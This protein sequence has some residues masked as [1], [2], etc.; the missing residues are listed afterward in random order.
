VPENSQTFQISCMN[1]VDGW[2]QLYSTGNFYG[3]P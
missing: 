3:K 2:A 1:P